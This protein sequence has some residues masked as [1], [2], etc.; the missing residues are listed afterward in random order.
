[1][2][3][4]EIERKFLVKKIPDLNSVQVSYIEQGYLSFSPEVRIR[5]KDDMFYLTV[6]SD[7]DIAREEY[8]IEISQNTYD[9]LTSQVKG[10][11]LKKMRYEIPL[12][13]SEVA[14]LDIYEN[15]ENL[16]MVEVEFID[17]D[18]ANAFEIP[19]WF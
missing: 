19:F 1:M 3:Q 5:K 12:N 9:E 7:G 13:K 10:L 8:E 4:V 6:K 17:I 15:F 18:S 14:E 16:K 11:V 2:F